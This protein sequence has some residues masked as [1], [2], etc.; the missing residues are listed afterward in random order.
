MDTN[1]LNSIES[2]TYLWPYIYDI[3]IVD[4][5]RQSIGAL[6]CQT[7]GQGDCSPAKFSQR[8]VGAVPRATS[9][10]YKPAAIYDVD[11]SPATERRTIRH[12]SHWSSTVLLKSDVTPRLM[13]SLYFSI[14]S[15]LSRCCWLR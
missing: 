5:Q 1:I 8:H 15:I 4:G 12:D 13:H 2:E 11:L 9:L 14:A 7:G 10:V 3:S 6:E